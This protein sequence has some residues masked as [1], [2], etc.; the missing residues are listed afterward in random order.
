MVIH[1][2]GKIMASSQTDDAKTALKSTFDR[3][4]STE[5]SH[6]IRWHGIFTVQ[7]ALK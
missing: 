4:I 5:I 3:R 7:T 1:H 2:T 6:I